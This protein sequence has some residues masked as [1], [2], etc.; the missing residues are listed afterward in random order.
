MRQEQNNP[1]NRPQT[2]W[3]LIGI[4]SA[5]LPIELVLHDIRTFG[6]RSIGPRAV[7]ALLIM[8]VFSGLF[9]NEDG[10]PISAF[11]VLT[12]VLAHDG[13]LYI[14]GTSRSGSAR[15]F[16]LQRSP[17]P[18]RAPAFA[19]D[20]DQ[21]YRAAVVIGCSNR[22]P[23]AQSSTG[24]LPDLGITL[25]IDQSRNNKHHAPTKNIEYARRHSA[26]L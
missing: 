24:R 11:I 6:V 19:G 12:F 16:L 20:L 22:H 23:S 8:I 3:L 18:I 7:F 17:V 4:L 5:G 14:R 2:N 9:P 1:D 25:R 15:P 13:T 21:R 10:R 26:T